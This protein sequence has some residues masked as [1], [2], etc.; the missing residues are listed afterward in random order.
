M[1]VSAASLSSDKLNIVIDGGLEP[2]YAAAG[3][4]VEVRLSLNG[5]KGICSMWVKLTWSD[6]LALQN[7]KYEFYDEN[8]DSAMVALPEDGASWN[9]VGNSFIFNWIWAK[10]ELKEDG[11]FITLTFKVSDDAKTGDVLSVTAEIDDD[12]LFNSSLENVAYNL[13]N[14]GVTVGDEATGTVPAV[15][16]SGVVT[17]APKNDGVNTTAI[18][19]AVVAGVAV[20]A[21]LVVIIL[22]SKRKNKA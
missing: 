2:K 16:D 7:A 21:V 11:A 19:I 14:G 4:L 15:T 13:I 8:D 6:K 3:E 12:N 20:A 9:T 18:I 5:N 17:E 10:N 1:C 22:I